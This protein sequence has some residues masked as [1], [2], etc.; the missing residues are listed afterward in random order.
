MSNLHDDAKNNRPV[1]I[2]AVLNWT[3]FD[4]IGDL[5]FGEPFHN[6][7]N[8]RPH[9]WLTTLFGMIRLGVI[10]M[11]LATIPGFSLLI[12]ALQN[13]TQT[14][15]SFSFV[16]HT[17]ELIERRI[18]HGANRPDFMTHVLKN[19]R[20][21]DTGM[22]KDEIEATMAFLV[23]A[24]SETTATLLSGC[25]YLL[26][27]NPD[28]MRKLRDELL[29]EFKTADDITLS[30]VNRLPYL[31]GVLEESLRFYPPVPV[32]LPRVVPPEGA[33]I[34]GYWVPGGVSCVTSHCGNS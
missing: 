4:I 15:D 27:R 24:G 5:C 8:R 1:D 32:S 6:L 30:R 31:F 10:A 22:T 12:R 25:L 13:Y 23:V 16:E 9:E 19:N 2:V 21:D 33:S 3:T 18:K 11:Q 28:K 20:D 26:L 34:S 29:A 14:E 7:E 17:H